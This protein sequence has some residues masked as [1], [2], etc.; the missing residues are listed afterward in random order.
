MPL[1]LMI[2]GMT[3]NLGAP[4]GWNEGKADNERCRSLPIRD[5]TVDGQPW[6]V[7]LHEF[8]PDEVERIK[9]GATLELWIAGV[10]HPVVGMLVRDVPPSE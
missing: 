1:A 2:Q 8:T 7:S 3:R 5:I 6:M 4:P 10:A 9:A